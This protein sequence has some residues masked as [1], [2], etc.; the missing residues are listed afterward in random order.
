MRGDF[1]FER[2]REANPVPEPIRLDEAVTDRAALLTAITERKNEMQTQEND[3]VATRPPAGPRRWLVAAAVAVV[4]LAAVSIIALLVRPD[5]TVATTIPSPET[6]ANP[7]PIL[8]E[9]VDA[10]NQGDLEGALAVLSPEAS[11]D[12]PFGEVDTCRDH[13]GYLIAI[14]THFEKNSCGESPPY[15]CGFDLTS[16]LHATMGYPNYALPMNPEVSLDGDGLLVADFFGSIPWET[17]P[18][19]PADSRDIWSYMGP[20]YP[21]LRV[22]QFGPSPY[23]A[24]AG[25]AAMDAARELNDPDAVVERVDMLLGR[26]G[27]PA[28]QCTTQDGNRFCPDLVAFLEAIGATFD[29]DCGSA[30]DGQIPC[31]LVVDSDI[32]QTLDSGPSTGDMTINY[33][34]GRAW[35]LDVDLWFSADTDVHDAFMAYAESQPG[36]VN[37]ST[38]RPIWTAESGPSWVQAAREFAAEG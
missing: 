28:Q 25:E 17:T 3:R 24:E 35:T 5:N 2:L 14:G 15:R 13:L 32:H 33:R 37:E 8:D 22:G 27:A 19:M 6:E 38:G 30:S 7:I 34:G 31:A 4:V 1:A 23:T 9:W 11:C 29:L 36:L 18:Y 16:E 10:M 26:Y 12:L 20:K 21:E